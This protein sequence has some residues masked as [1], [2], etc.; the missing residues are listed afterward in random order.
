MEV[1]LDL[2]SQ[3]H[4]EDEP[5]INMDEASVQLTGHVYQLLEMEPNQDKK[6]D[7]HYTREGVQALFMFFDPNRGW[8]RV[9][10]RDHR[11]RVDWAE[12]VRQL[13]DVDYPQA[14]KVKLVCDNLNTHNIWAVK[15]FMT[16]IIYFLNVLLNIYLID[17]F[18]GVFN[19]H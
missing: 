2:Y 3:V 11:T 14:R 5:L 12:E 8:R 16:E 9:S 10:N 1:V 19:H 13:L 18:L 4:S 7:Y 17:V 15:I 6:E